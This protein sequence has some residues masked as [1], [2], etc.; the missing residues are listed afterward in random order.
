MHAS[1][2]VCPLLPV[3]PLETRT[4]LVLV[5]HRL[6]QLG[7]VQATVPVG[8]REATIAYVLFVE[9]QGRG[10][11]REAVGA[12]LEHLRAAY[13]VRSAR[14]T[15]DTRNARSMGLLEAL[16][17]TRVAVRVGAET[18][19]EVLTDEAEYRL[20]LGGEGRLVAGDVAPKSVGDAAGSIEGDG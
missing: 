2:C 8:G 14:A 5:I 19:G 4:R 13:G 11:A 20:A 10:V 9:A 16:G 15:V 3:P 18:M 7:Y 12:M 17:F 1:L 6:E